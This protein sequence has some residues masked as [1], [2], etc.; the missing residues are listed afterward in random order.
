LVNGRTY[1]VKVV[2]INSFGNSPE[3]SGSNVTPRTVS[4]APDSLTATA[5]NASVRLSWTAPVN[6]G[7]VAITGYRIES[8]TASTGIWSTVVADTSSIATSETITSLVNGTTYKFRVSAINAAGVSVASGEV[9]ALPIGAPSTPAAPTAGVGSAQ[10]F[11]S[12]SAPANNGSPI[13][14]YEIQY[15]TSSSGP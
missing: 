9:N 7:G 8:S 4:S 10:I 1:N 6:N 13:T 3:S 15:S 12:W 11:L 14:D 2:A 5:G